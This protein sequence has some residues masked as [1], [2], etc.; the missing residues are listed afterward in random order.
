MNTVFNPFP[1]VV[2]AAES[3]IAHEAG[4]TLTKQGE[5]ISP[6]E[7]FAVGGQ[8]PGIRYPVSYPYLTKR[9][10]VSQWLQALPHNVIHVGTWTEDGTVYVDATTIVSD[11]DR[12]IQLGEQRGEIAVY[13]FAN[14]ESLYMGDEQPTERSYDEKLRLA[15]KAAAFDA[16]WAENILAS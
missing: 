8:V 2:K 9:I 16:D 14:Q 7:G 3:V 1:D 15:T 5:L 4:A 13:D 10:I 12:A 6:T 11:R